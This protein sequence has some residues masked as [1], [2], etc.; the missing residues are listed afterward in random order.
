MIITIGFVFSNNVCYNLPT[1][2]KNNL[3]LIWDFN[4]I[5][6]LLERKDFSLLFG[7]DA[8]W[9]IGIPVAFIL[10]HIYSFFFS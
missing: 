4:I 1:I 2:I 7:K 6:T 10:N 5:K 8:Y 9:A 3:L